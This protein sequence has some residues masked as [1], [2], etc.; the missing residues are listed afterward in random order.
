VPVAVTEVP[1]G[2]GMDVVL[3]AST[4]ALRSLT[5]NGKHSFTNNADLERTTEWIMLHRELEIGSEATPHTHKATITLSWV[6]PCNGYT[7]PFAG[8]EKC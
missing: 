6:V 7:A 1:I 4:P 5:I 3:D 8:Y 2:K